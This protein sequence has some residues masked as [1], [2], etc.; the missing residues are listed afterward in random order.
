EEWTPGRPRPG[1]RAATRRG[2]PAPPRWGYRPAAPAPERLSLP[3]GGP[4]QRRL[5]KRL[6][7]ASLRGHELRGER[8]LQAPWAGKADGDAVDH[9]PRPARHHVDAVGKVHGLLHVVGHEE[10]GLAVL[11]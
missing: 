2:P 9:P 4:G 7:E 3:L 6:Q 5:Q 1:R 11:L 8:R 10:D